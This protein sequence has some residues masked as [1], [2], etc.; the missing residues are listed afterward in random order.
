M[1]FVIYVVY[2]FNIFEGIHI[3]VRANERT[4][5]IRRYGYLLLIILLLLLRSFVW[6]LFHLHSYI[7]ILIRIFYTFVNNAGFLFQKKISS[8]LH[9]L[10][11]LYKNKDNLHRNWPPHEIRKVH[12]C[13]LR[14]CMVLLLHY[15]RYL[16]T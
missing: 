5:F 11:Y 4:K 16:T 9:R 3:F 7:R 15:Q 13:P 1:S 14:M 10:N 2:V 12:A 6:T 8:N